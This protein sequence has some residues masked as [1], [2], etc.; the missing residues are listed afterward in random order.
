MN[1]QTQIVYNFCFHGNGTNWPSE[2]LH[3]TAISK[4]IFLLMQ[5]EIWIIYTHTGNFTSYLQNQK[6]KNNKTI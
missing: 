5:T 3:N 4:Q 2:I 1:K 6:N